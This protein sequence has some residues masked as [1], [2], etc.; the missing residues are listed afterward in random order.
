[1]KA[2][3]FWNTVASNSTDTPLTSVHPP[4]LTLKVKFKQLDANK[5]DFTL[6]QEAGQFIHH[7]ESPSLKFSFYFIVIKVYYALTCLF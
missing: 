2:T 1:M 7:E 6:L 4:C 5:H 3:A